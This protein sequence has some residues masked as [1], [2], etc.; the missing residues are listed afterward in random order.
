MQ[1]EVPG[2][3]SWSPMTGHVGKAQSTMP[4]FTVRVMKHW[5]RLLREVAD[6]LWLSVDKKHLDDALS[7]MPWLLVSPG[8]LWQLG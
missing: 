5:N 3:S 4:F 8:M 1:S 6:A 2:C 7:K